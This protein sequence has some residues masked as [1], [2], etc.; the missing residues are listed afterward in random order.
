[1]LHRWFTDSV[2][3]LPDAC[4]LEVGGR[5]YTY[6]ELDAVSRGIAGRLRRVADRPRV[7]LLATRSVVAYAGYLAALRVGGT[8]VPLNAGYPHQRLAG[9]IAAAAPH[10]LVADRDQDSSFAAELPVLRF[11]TESVAAFLAADPEPAEDHPGA[12]DNPAYLLFTS[13]S[14]GRPKGVPT[15]HGNVDEYVRYQLERFEVGP[16]ARLSQ[17]YQLSF[18]PSVF[19]L[20]VAWG[21]GATLVVPTPEELFDPAAFVTGRAITHW[22]SVPSLISTSYAAGLLPA[23]CMPGLRWSMFCGEQLTR[24]QAAR[25]MDA[26]PEVTVENGYGPTETT[27]TCISWRVPRDRTAWPVTP[28]GTLPIGMPFPHVEGMVDE[29]TGE[30][31][32]RGSQRF[33]GYLDPA[34]NAGRFT[35]LAGDLPTPTDWYRTG[36]RV[37]VIDGQYVHLGRIDFQVKVF[38]QRVELPEIEHLLRS[39]AGLDDAVVALVEGP[40]GKELAAVYCGPQT[41]AR[42]VRDQ[43]RAHLPVAL[44]PRRF[45]RVDALPRNDNGKTDR[46]ACAALLATD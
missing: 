4:A 45:V 44:I 23:G 31:L 32:I 21:G 8:V 24:E 25:W 1:M 17:T 10:V 40:R 37:T 27:V 35:P 46:R 26:A 42:Q 41:T 6:A 20:F 2:A 34:D 13:G 12:P 18:D 9:I 29:A 11:G 5:G 39:Y 36:D 33:A 7:G 16:G 15:R 3:K 22:S 38:G 19:D 43:L 14:T 28:N 30:L